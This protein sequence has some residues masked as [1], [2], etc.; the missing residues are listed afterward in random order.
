MKQRFSSLDVKVIAHELSQ[1]LVTLRLSNVYDLSSKIL[2][3]KFAKPNDKKQMIIDC[4]FRCH[5]TDFA[6]TTAA[7]PSAFVARLR[8]FLKT[9]RVTS[10]SQIGTDRIIEFQF[11]DGQYRLFLE[12][13]ASGN[14]ILTDSD[15]KILTLMRNVPEGEGQE[16]QRV[17]LTYSLENRQNYGGVPD[18][19]KER[20]RNA[21]QS[22]SEKSA[23][24]AAA[25]KKIRRK[26]GDEL[27]RGLATTLNELPPILVDHAFQATKFDHTAKPADILE[28][29]SLFDSLFKALT[30]ARLVVDN[31]STS[32][33]GKGYIIAKKKVDLSDAA[34]AQ[35]PQSQEAKPTGLLY[36][37]FHPF[38]PSQ[39]EGNQA[40]AILTF[41]TFNKTVDEFFSSIEGQKLESRLSERE[42]AAKRKLDAAK[43]D[44]AKRLEG[45]QEAQLLNLRK[46]AAIEANVE[47]VQEAMDAVTGLLQQGMDWV[48]IGKLV[49]REQ[50]RHNPV[51]EIIKLPLNLADHS[52][53]IVISEEEAAVEEDED[54]G[55][56]TES[57]V[58]DDAEESEIDAGKK[59]IAQSL[60]V[61]IKLG[62]SPFSNAREYYEQ[63]RSAAEKE[64][65]TMQQSV[66]ALKNAEQKIA[67]DLRKGLKQEK[68]VL[69]PIRRQLW[70]E[71]FLWFISSDGYLVLGGRDA[72]QNEMLY[73]RYLRKGDV[74][75]H[76]D[77]HGAAT[78]IIKNN[79]KTP[80]API[81][82]STLSQA[83]NLAVCSS[84]AWDSKAGMGAWWVYADQVS[85]S[86]PTGEYLSTGSFMVRGQ[87]NFLPPAQLLLGFGIMF[88]ISEESKG[89][90]VKHRLHD[91]STTTTL[92]DATSTI[93]RS[94]E[95][96]DPNR[97][98]NDAASESDEDQNDQ[99]DNLARENPL[100]SSNRRDSVEGD[101]ADDEERVP[102][103]E[104]AAMTLDDQPQMPEEAQPD[105]E[106]PDVE[107]G[108]A[109]EEEDN[110]DAAS[111]RPPPSTSTAP[112]SKP[113][114]TTSQKKGRPKRG[115]RG[116][117][118]KIAAKYKDQDE[119][120]RAAI[121]DLIGASAGR[122]KAEAE[123]QAKAQRE[124]EAEAAR[125]R[126][127]AQ[128]QRQQ[129]ET[130]EHEE[131]R[132]MML[133]EGVEM[134]DDAELEKSTPLDALVGTPLA[135]D[136]I[137]EAMPICAPWTA[138]AKCKY[139][140]KL[141]PGA[142]KK[143]K[144]VKE[145][146]DRWRVASG[147]KGVLDENARDSERMWP[148]EIELIKA[149]KPEE[150]INC[151]PVADGF[152][153]L[154][155]TD[156]LPGNNSA[157]M[158]ASA[159]PT[160][161]QSI[162]VG[163][164]GESLNFKSAT[165]DI[166]FTIHSMPDIPANAQII[167]ICAL[168]KEDA[169]PE[170]HGWIVSDLLAFKQLMF[171]EGNKDA[172]I[173]MSTADLAT[174]IRDTEDKHAHVESIDSSSEPDMN[175]IKGKDISAATS[176]LPFK[177]FPS[178]S[179][180]HLG[181]I[182][183]VRERA[184]LAQKNKT[185]L[186]IFGMG[187]SNAT[188]DLIIG[189]SSEIVTKDRLSRATGNEVPLILV[190]PAAFSGGWQINTELGEKH[191]SVSNAI[192]K[193]LIASWCKTTF[194]PKITSNEFASGDLGQGGV[195]KGSAQPLTHI[196]NFDPSCD[197]WEKLWAS[198]VGAPL[199]YWQRKWNK[200]PAVEF[201]RRSD[202]Y[203]FLGS[204]F[205]GTQSSQLAHVRFLVA[206]E[207]RTCIGDWDK[208][209][210]TST[211]EFLQDFI[212]TE[213]VTEKH[214]MTSHDAMAKSSF[215]SAWSTLLML[216][217][218][219]P[220]PD[221]TVRKTVK[222][223]T[224]CRPTFYL[225]AAVMTKFVLYQG[226]DDVDTINEFV[227]VRIGGAIEM[228]SNEISRQSAEREEAVK[229]KGAE[230]KAAELK[231]A[232]LKAAE[233]KAAELK[234]AEI[235]AS[236]IETAL[237]RQE[238]I[239]RNVDKIKTAKLEEASQRKVDEYKAA[240]APHENPVPEAVPVVE[241]VAKT[242]ANLKPEHQANSPPR[243]LRNSRW[244]DDTAIVKEPLT[245]QNPE[246]I[247]SHTTEPVLPQKSARSFVQ[248]STTVLPKNSQDSAIARK[249]LLNDAI[250]DLVKKELSK[251]G[252]DIS[253][254]I[255]AF[256]KKM[257]LSDSSTATTKRNSS[258]ASPPSDKSDEV[259]N[260]AKPPDSE[261]L[262]EINLASCG[263]IGVLVMNV[264]S[265]DQA[266][267]LFTE[268][269]KP[270]IVKI[271]HRGD[272]LRA[273]QFR[274]LEERDMAMDRLPNTLKYKATENP[275]KPY[276]KN[277]QPPR[278]PSLGSMVDNLIQNTPGLAG[279]SK[280]AL[281]AFFNSI[282]DNLRT[283][284]TGKSTSS[285]Q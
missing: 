276:V 12:F 62:I 263:M 104:V 111:E 218:G 265:D 248:E 166:S 180:L 126:R 216:W 76:A 175:Q 255:T 57:T 59:R 257:R 285:F 156:F 171:K 93:D 258:V 54:E 38:L 252:N 10:V 52:I 112:T 44:Q 42:A 79:P 71:K 179:K 19:T 228:I 273:V 259:A 256:E 284:A 26:A 250:K 37:D 162:E 133:D 116:K 227:K 190:T 189:S 203:G 212:D 51:A 167:G 158:A 272:A 77:L 101:D 106:G 282:A 49:A 188:Q 70:F 69:Q 246:K 178:M 85:K 90:H 32:E 138:M 48:D 107:Q 36:E 15:L 50:K 268:E 219:A 34:D 122:Q 113:S 215:A 2:L 119:E 261:P 22:I 209:F 193:N 25:G 5:L 81:P 78:V 4:G 21:L 16:P 264:K 254:I 96:L 243:T 217:P 97:A 142:Q 1:A 95:A 91:N 153:L 226:N 244:S 151:V 130:A 147:K 237:R 160:A 205:G 253:D 164:D 152:L 280:D 68:A 192:R 46:A 194:T 82:P 137:L 239:Q 260:V 127:R 41:D 168:N 145:I 89:K 233:L 55:Y 199:T 191:D 120:D 74:Y 31:I 236:V 124:A 238:A 185:A 139:K 141:Q 40:W 140:A 221:S 43:Q 207:L 7:V 114:T 115:Q 110:D 262:P 30:E 14:V 24:T 27:R 103:Q 271:M 197:E 35:E 23:A 186:V 277:F 9:R 47:R 129:K 206:H 174:A 60:E 249:E 84:N 45:L 28:N 182:K 102:D 8:K 176:G 198:R 20:V 279:V 11:S 63:K 73:K 181:F 235:R 229:R 245:F 247:T 170:N 58:S 281:A 65:R 135:G 224:Y 17:G 278:E 128:H 61:D 154:R 143:G 134:L 230:L 202:G 83:G 132:R 29:E 232:E 187:L 267:D 210:S 88:K 13:F 144:A 64:Q 204:A 161:T 53:T 108:V 123:A 240:P 33:T 169:L 275:L 39:F 136:E 18:L 155:V 242:K 283:P 234:A 117:A 100:Q 98:D 220:P 225:A 56:D 66:T 270:K 131:I 109:E 195:E 241:A 86:A 269:D 200:F 163:F 149:L 201:L 3:L 211:K 222:D 172:Q 223:T 87:K 92:D 274:T 214:S 105:Q 208:A 231:A 157:N 72:Q 251:N 67:E 183:E 266:R 146:L 196:F 177:V 94:E 121:E 150:C 159:E 80:D 213:D 75:V 99:E 6:R 165:A 148:R 184:K 173:W 125:E 118:K